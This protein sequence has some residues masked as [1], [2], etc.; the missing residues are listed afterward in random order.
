MPSHGTQTDARQ[1]VEAR[2]IAIDAIASIGSGSVHTVSGSGSGS[3]LA[4]NGGHNGHNGGSGW[5]SRPIAPEI[6]RR[7]LHLRDR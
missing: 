6:R 5:D 3:R 7:H 4:V 2:A 1:E